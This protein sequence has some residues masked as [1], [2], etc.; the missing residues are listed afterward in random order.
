[1]YAVM[2]FGKSFTSICCA[3]EMKAKLVVVV[4]AKADVLEEWKHT[5]QSHVDFANYGFVFITSKD[6]N[7]DNN[8]ITKCLKAKQKPVVFLTLQD[9]CGK[10]I[11]TKHKELFGKNRLID[12]LIVDE[13][14]FGARADEYGKVLKETEKDIN[15]SDYSN[16]E[17]CGIYHTR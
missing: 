12:L 11:K 16:E 2:R 1:M 4:T 6:L 7:R 17:V 13:T 14:H 9:L 15:V 8:L 3:K 5:V 10:E